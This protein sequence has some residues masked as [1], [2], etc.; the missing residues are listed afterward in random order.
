[1]SSGGV[2]PL[3]CR[4]RRIQLSSGQINALPSSCRLPCDPLPPPSVFARSAGWTLSATEFCFDIRFF[5]GHAGAIARSLLFG[6]SLRIDCGNRQQ[7]NAGCMGGRLHGV[8]CL[9]ARSLFRLS[10]DALLLVTF[11]TRD[12]ARERGPMRACVQGGVRGL[13]IER[14]QHVSVFGCDIHR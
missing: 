12:A 2:R 14:M 7:H 4:S 3:Y 1:M 5:H 6:L 10:S 8:W 11:R 13:G 9:A